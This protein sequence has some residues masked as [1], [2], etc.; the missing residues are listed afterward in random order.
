MNEI[1]TLSARDK[2]I[3]QMVEQGSDIE[4]A[5]KYIDMLVSK[6][7]KLTW[8]PGSLVLVLSPEKNNATEK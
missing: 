5:T 8:M 4:A 2:A 1:T 3:E 7:Y 6:G